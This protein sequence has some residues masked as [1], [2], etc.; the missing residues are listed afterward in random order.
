VN[1]LKLRISSAVQVFIIPTFICLT[2][3]FLTSCQENSNETITATSGTPQ[4]SAVNTAFPLTLQATV[5]STDG[6]GPHPVIGVPVTFAAP[7]PGLNSESPSGTFASNLITETDTTDANGVATSSKFRAN[8]TAGAYS[9]TASVT[10]TSTPASFSLTNT[11]PA[12]AT[13]TAVGGTPQS[14]AVGTGFGQLLA[15]NVVDKFGN[16]VSGVDVT[17]TAPAAGASGI[18]ADS[19][20][21]TESDTTD[22]NGT[23]TSLGF[24]ANAIAGGPYTVTAT[25]AGVATPANFMLTNTAAAGGST[26]TSTG[27]TPQSA[28]VGTPF[29]AALVA[30]VTSGGSPA[31]GVTVTFTAPASGASGIFA[32]SGTATET[33]ATNASGVATSSQFTANTRA[34]A[35]SV[36]ASVPGAAADFSL[37]NAAGAAATITATGGTPQS[38]TVGTPFALPLQATVVDSDSNPVSGAVVTFTPLTEGPSG[39]FAS[40]STP[41]ERDTTNASGVATSSTFT[42]DL[43][44]GG[45]YTMTGTVAGVATAANFSLTNTPVAGLNNY[46]FYLSGADDLPKASIG[47]YA[48]AGSVNINTDGTV[49]GGEQ[50]YNDTSGVTSPQP[51]G[52][53]VTGGTLTVSATTGQGTLSLITNNANVGVNGT[54]TFGVQFVNSKHALIMQFDGSATSSGS[55]DL[56]TQ[57]S[58]PSLGSGGYAFT[59]SGV[60]TSY[61]PI[62]YG[63]VFTIPNSGANLE[64][65]LYD[66]NDAGD[67]VKGTTLTGTFTEPDSFGRGTIASSLHYLGI[68]VVLSYYVVGP[69]AIRIIDVDTNDSA[70][71]SA[72]GQGINATTASNASLG[73]PCPSNSAQNCSVFA[74]AGNPKF[75]GYGVLGE[76]STSNTSSLT[77]DFSGV[78]DDNELVHFV[79][80]TASTI[81]GTYSIASSGY[82]SLTITGL[83]EFLNSLGIYVTDPTLNLSDPNSNTGG[84]GA[85]VLD[86]DEDLPGSTGVMIPQTDTA[87]DDFKGNYAVA[88]QDFNDFTQCDLCEFDLVGQASVAG[89]VASGTS[90]I[91]DPLFTL[92][93]GSATNSGVTLSG[94]LVADTNNPGRYTVSPLE[95]SIP[96]ISSRDLYVVIYQASGGQLFWLEEDS[97]GVWLGPLQQQGSLIGPAAKKPAAKT[98]PK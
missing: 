36:T 74:V 10:G 90:L 37:T 8:A 97:N 91:S 53:K 19:E 48:L 42:A 44:S 72:F 92:G 27:G 41:T 60:D 76:F 3:G 73:G 69:E 78:G 18:F 57:T 79:K 39:T 2:L 56:Q 29:A 94:S 13:I 25:V 64:D 31:S 34:G 70:I 82:G 6:N 81:S 23:A 49:V 95:L 35:Y 20:M 85:L 45:P 22:G 1:R 67:V 16:P 61:E 84:G 87:T 9:V 58:P 15:A 40:N 5:T 17:F 50:D 86:L 51:S 12:A 68:P 46:T 28:A 77:A 38:A 98:Q 52:D 83:S 71:G 54:E 47:F 66:F 30:T 96:G 21:A 33:E 62:A 65:G 11:V 88:A 75:S 59:L 63:G 93:G 89:G 4:S 55:M 80:A 26:I 14:A 32:S 43:L 7:F 24:I